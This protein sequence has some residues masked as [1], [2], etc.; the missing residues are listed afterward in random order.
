MIVQIPGTSLV[1][2][3]KSMALINQDKNGLD[4]YLKKRQSMAAQKEEINTMKADI[5]GIKD[6]LSELKSM[7][8]QLLSKGSNV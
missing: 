1:R 6:D 8:A 5:S 7:I 3:T 2:D 4:E